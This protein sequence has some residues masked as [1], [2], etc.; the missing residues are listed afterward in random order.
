MVTT[1]DEKLARRIRSL[2]N[3]GEVVKYDHAEKGLNARLDTLQ[4]AILKVKLDHLTEW[5]QKRVAHAQR[6]RLL[7]E[8][9]GGIRLQ[10]PLPE[11]KHVYHLFIGETSRRDA[12]REFLN[13]CGV[14]TGIHYP[15]RIYLQ[16]A[17]SDLGYRKGDFPNAETLAQRILSL[18]M[19]AELM[20]EQIE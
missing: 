2:R 17:Y 8:T 10:V 6:Y 14:Q 18:P 4:A 1:N 11:S 20:E 9:V 13:E 15:T 19:F 5:N 12:L 3:Y 7:L 16:T